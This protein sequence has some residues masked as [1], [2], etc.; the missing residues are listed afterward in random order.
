MCFKLWWMCDACNRTGESKI[1][2]VDDGTCINGQSFPKNI[3]IDCH[4]PEI[5]G[6]PKDIS[7]SAVFICCTQSWQRLE[8]LKEENLCLHIINSAGVDEVIL[9]H[10]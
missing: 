2:Q 8:V 1:S 7:K 5:H 10:R 3:V 9:T 6:R 4:N